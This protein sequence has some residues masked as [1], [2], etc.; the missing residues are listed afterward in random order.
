MQSRLRRGLGDGACHNLIFWTWHKLA[1]AA[2]S[3]APERR[4]PHH[5]LACCLQGV[6]RSTTIVIGYLMWKLGKPYDEVYQT[7]RA[8][9]GVASPNIGF[10]CQLLQWQVRP[11][12]GLWGPHAPPVLK[13]YG[14]EGSAAGSAAPP[15]A[16]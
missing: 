15:F 6:S 7:V 8:L 1:H 16:A 14:P 12:M 10:T 9:R 4:L 11:S 2:E 5:L 13:G 3:A